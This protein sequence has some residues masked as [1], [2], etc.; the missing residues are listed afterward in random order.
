[1]P[2]NFAFFGFNALTSSRA[3]QGAQ[4]AL[5]TVVLQ[6]PCHACLHFVCFSW[7]GSR[8]FQPPHPSPQVTGIVKIYSTCMGRSE[9][10]VAYACCVGVCTARCGVCWRAWTVPQSCL[11][12][13][14]K[15]SLTNKSSVLW[16]KRPPASDKMTPSPLSAGFHGKLPPSSDKMP[17]TPQKWGFFQWQTALIQWQ[18]GASTYFALSVANC[19]CPVK[20]CPP[21]PISAGFCGKLPPASNRMAQPSKL[22]AILSLAGAFCLLDSLSE[23]KWR[24]RQKNSM[25]VEYL[26]RERWFA[27]GHCFLPTPGLLNRHMKNCIHQ[28]KQTL[29]K[30]KGK[31]P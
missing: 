11:P 1:M 27:L 13:T 19:P 3:A 12:A 14:G 5:R 22:W 9:W 8:T 24:R 26:C 29:T 15:V 25:A 21:S 2:S 16:G 7:T 30:A 18:N 31:P 10:G 28:P 23:W 17:P 6:F 20:K 4:V